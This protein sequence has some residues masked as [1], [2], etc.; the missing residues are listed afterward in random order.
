MSSTQSFYVNVE[1]LEVRACFTSAIDS[2]CFYNLYIKR[3]MVQIMSLHRASYE[4]AS[5]KTA[6][7]KE[8]VHERA[9]C[10]IPQEV[11]EV[12]FR[13]HDDTALKK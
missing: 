3:N 5:Y 1:I 13:G 4:R 7:S 12:L 2:G 9:T 8:L 6:S 10:R 11:H